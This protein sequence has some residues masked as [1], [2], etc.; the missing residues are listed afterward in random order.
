MFPG[1][2]VIPCPLRWFGEQQIFVTV[3]NC[4][5]RLMGRCDEIL[6]VEQNVCPFQKISLPNR[7]QMMNDDSTKY[8]MT[9]NAK[10]AAKISCDHRVSDLLPF[11]RPV[12]DLVHITVEAESRFADDAVKPKI[13]KAIFKGWKKNKL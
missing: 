9:F 8:L 10:V 11:Q 2:G 7:V 4:L 13:L 5:M 6:R 1:T 3:V 12:K